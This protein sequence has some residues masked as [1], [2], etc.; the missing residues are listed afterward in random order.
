LLIAGWAAAPQFGELRI[1]DLRDATPAEWI[2]RDGD[3]APLLLAAKRA[4]RG[5]AQ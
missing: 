5:L 4:A 3:E 1:D 2:S